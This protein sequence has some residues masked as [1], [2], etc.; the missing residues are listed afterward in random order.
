MANSAECHR[1]MVIHHICLNKSG[2]EKQWLGRLFY[3]TITKLVK[4]NMWESHV[5][6]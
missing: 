2:K 5:V 1:E 3:W 6:T 4:N